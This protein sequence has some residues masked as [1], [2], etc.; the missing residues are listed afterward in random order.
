MNEHI[1]KITAETPPLARVLL[2]QRRA[3]AVAVELRLVMIEVLIRKVRTAQ[4]RGQR[5]E[6]FAHMVNLNHV[7]DR[8]RRNERALAFDHAHQPLAPGPE[9]RF[10]HWRSAYAHTLGQRAFKQRVT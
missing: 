10:P 6:S 4:A 8:K 1:V 5:L 9:Y 2:A 3:R 7:F